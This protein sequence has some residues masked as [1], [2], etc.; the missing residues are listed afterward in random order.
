VDIRV[1][2]FNRKGKRMNKFWKFANA[3]VSSGTGA[4]L[5]L[6]GVIA[7][8]SWWGDEVTPAAFREELK[9]H[10]GDL[11][12]RINS[13]GGDV[14]AGLSIYNALVEHDGKVTVKVDGIAA[15]IASLVA[16]AGDTIVMNPGAMMM[17]H[18][19]WTVAMGNADDMKEAAEYLE[20][21]GSS[22]A[23]IYAERTGK[24]EDE[25]NVLL[26]AET[27][28]T[29]SEAVELGF[30]DEAIKPKSSL[31]EAV[32]DA[33]AYLKPVKAALMEPVMSL[34]TKLEADHDTEDVKEETDVSTDTTET[35]KEVV[36]PETPVVT[37]TEVEE[38]KQPEVEEKEPAKEEVVEPPVV[39]TNNSTVKETKMSKQDDIATTQVLE[40]KGQA[41]VDAKPVVTVKD[42]LKTKESMEAFARI[43]EENAVS[44]NAKDVAGQDGASGVRA[45]WKNHLET[46]MGVTNPEIFLPT[47]LIQEIEDAF[48]TG[49]EIWQRVSKTGMDSFNAAW[50]V[51]DDP[52][53]ESG[54]A[55]GYN[56]AEEAEK[57]EQTLTIA[58]RILRPQFVYKYITL[59]REDVKEQRSTGALVRFVLSELPKRIIR[60][61]ER[62]IVI[63]DGRAPGSDYKIQEGSPRGFYPVAADAAAD[64]AFATTYTPV[65]GQSV[66]ET[67]RRARALVKADGGVIL[68]A[69]EGLLL[70]M[71]FEQNVNGGFLFAPGSDLNR[72]IKVDAVVEP[73]WMDNDEN[74]AYIFA[75]NYYR[76]VGDQS[77][78]AFQNFLLKT[79]KNEYLQEIWAGGGLTALK[80]AVAVE[81]SET[82]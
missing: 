10:S 17:V 42:Y 76:V 73:E 79:N 29:A 20:K 63:G 43:L 1:L 8:E 70:D 7:S 44:G 52:D 14:Y 45:A 68:V 47:P 13:P 81:A 67:L 38:V 39:E 32:K 35:D 3:E 25:I 5:I 69:K 58:N 27:W 54:R 37:D 57:S 51:N 12:V 56:R 26:D 41:P 24:T 78:E 50:D 61:V 59:N 65:P 21:V 19:P 22:L 49:G 16:M 31:G 48:K 33:M 6:E 15:S 77:V 64:N 30:A 82:S 74:D 53:A 40:P 23:P 66:Y 2:N 80:S 46:K 34:Q 72:Y 4:E 55:K 18:K 60:E 62:A 28:M 9:N 11:T 71:E 36:E 75:Y